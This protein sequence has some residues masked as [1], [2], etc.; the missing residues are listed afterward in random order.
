M[1]HGQIDTILGGLLGDYGLECGQRG[2]SARHGCSHV[3]VSCKEYE[4]GV[5][6]LLVCWM[7]GSLATIVYR[8][9]DVYMNLG[10][11][12]C[13]RPLVVVVWQLEV[14]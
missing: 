6:G 14:C 13:Y 2:L 5:V 11:T 10:I 8:Y 4:V 3:S 7:G 12:I 9:M 1:L